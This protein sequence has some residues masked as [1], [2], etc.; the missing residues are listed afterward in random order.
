LNTLARSC[1]NL[2]RI[3]ESWP[4]MLRLAGSLVTGTVRAYDL[5]R[6]LSRDGRPS[7]LGQALAEYGRIAKTLHLLAY[8]DTDDSYRRQIGAQLNIQES[9]HQL[10]RRIFHGQRG[11]LRQRYREGQEDQLGALG[12]VL[13]AV[14][15]W[16]TRYMTWPLPNSEPGASRARRR[17]SPGSRRWASGTSTSWAATPS[18]CP[19]PAGYVPCA[20]RRRPTMRTRRSRDRG[21]SASCSV[22]DSSSEHLPQGRAGRVIP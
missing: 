18:P 6:T 16:N 15:L 21:A 9:R 13:N 12:L 10:A 11:E 22:G 4:D 2:D 7:A 8:V 5:L 19:S 3:R 17:T 1:V 20:I 14:V